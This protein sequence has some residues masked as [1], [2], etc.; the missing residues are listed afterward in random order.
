MKENGL[1]IDYIKSDICRIYGTN[2]IEWG[3][4]RH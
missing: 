4:V 3:G 1:L 2:I